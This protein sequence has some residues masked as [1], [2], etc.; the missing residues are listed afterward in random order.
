MT[1]RPWSTGEIQVLKTYKSLGLEV[2]AELLERTPSSVEAKASE[3]SISLVAT[4]EDVDITGSTTA[5]LGRIREMQA[6][7]ICPMCGKRLATMKN[8]G[9]CRAC[10]LDG[11]IS[12]RES[13]LAEQVRERKLVKLRQ[14]K[15]RMRVCEVCE[16]PFFPRITSQAQRCEDCE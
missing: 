10:H 13:Q 12:L 3:L 11:L 7:Q 2:V 1:I 5:I 15:K 14:D 6:L 9:I 8:T 4:G 16:R